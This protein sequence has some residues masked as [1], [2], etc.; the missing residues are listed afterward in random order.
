MRR[1]FYQVVICQHRHDAEA[2]V[3]QIALP[4]DDAEHFVHSRQSLDLGKTTVSMSIIISLSNPWRMQNAT[5]WMLPGEIFPTEVRATCHG[6]SAAT[7]KVRTSSGCAA[8]ALRSWHP[9]AVVRVAVCCGVANCLGCP[10]SCGLFAW[11]RMWGFALGGFSSW[12]LLAECMVV[13]R[14]SCVRAT[15]SLTA[16]IQRALGGGLLIKGCAGLQGFYI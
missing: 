9:T 16:P 4:E 12:R 5:T 7:G 2:A 14:V 8:H 13:C 3:L 10:W 1:V 11:H 6:I 15:L